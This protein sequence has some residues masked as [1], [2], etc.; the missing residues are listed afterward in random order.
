MPY[1]LRGGYNINNQIKVVF[2]KEIR[3]T[4]KDRKF[5]LSIVINIIILTF[6]LF[7]LHYSSNNDIQSIISIIIL[8]SLFIMLIFSFLFIKEK[9]WNVKEVNGFQSLI[10]LPLT[11]RDI[12]LGKIAAILVLSYYSTV[13]I[14]IILISAYF[15]TLGQ[16]LFIIINSSVWI[17]FF[18]V[19][20]LLIMVYN[21]ISSWIVHR[22]DNPIVIDVLQY[23]A[24][25]IFVLIFAIYNIFIVFQ[26]NDLTLI[27]GGILIIG[28]NISIIYLLTANLTKE[29]V[30]T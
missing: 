23:I 7:T 24:V 15:L 4:L 29:Y 19:G 18:I 26:L 9:F 10:T 27:F 8:Y 3:E 14:T 1:H 16:N 22:L 21:S 25:L 11:L 30:I 28:I 2:L 17:F 6:M 12:W 13:L 5:I 20:P